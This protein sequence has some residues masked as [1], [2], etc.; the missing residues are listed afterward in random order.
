M[1]RARVLRWL[2]TN[3]DSVDVFFVLQAAAGYG[4]FVSW[5]E[6]LVRAIRGEDSRKLE[7]ALI[8]RRAHRVLGAAIRSP[9]QGDSHA[10]RR[11]G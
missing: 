9:R 10:A 5:A 3:V 2:K 11:G 8:L 6:V 7:D 1:S 4:A